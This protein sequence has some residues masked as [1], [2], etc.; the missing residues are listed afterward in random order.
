MSQDPKTEKETV[1]DGEDKSEQLGRTGQGLRV[2]AL[3]PP[4]VKCQKEAPKAR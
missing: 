1:R 3:P 4:E 2:M